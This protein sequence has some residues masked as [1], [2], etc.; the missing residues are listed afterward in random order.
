[1]ADAPI[2]VARVLAAE[3]GDVLEPANYIRG[4]AISGRLRL[5]RLAPGETDP[6]AAIAEAVAPSVTPEALA[7]LRAADG[8]VH[9]GYLWANE[10]SDAT[11]DGRYGRFLAQIADFYLDL[12][13]DGL[14]QPVDADARVEDIF[15]ASSVL[16]R[17]F[18]S[19]A[20]GRYA[21]VLANFLAAAHAQPD[22]GLWWH[23]GA[24]PFYW[25]RGNAFAA[26]G[27]S[28]GLSY[29]PE[30][31]PQRAALEATHRA[32]IETLITHQDSSGAWRQVIDRPDSYLELTATAM[33]GIALSRG[34]ARGWLP[35]SMGYAAAGAWAAVAERIDEAGMV[36]DACMGTGPMPALD[37]YLNRAAVSGH[38]DRAGSMALWFAVE[39][40]SL[41]GDAAP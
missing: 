5:H 4:V 12:R 19:T 40:A 24:S 10:L 25:G 22:S 11:G 21:E 37:D 13:S 34:M 33:I 2:E 1:M 31:H 38:D 3:Y 39:Y 7:A 36:R 6:A 8:S 28:E 18:E 30:A 17:A 35:A 23:C 26:L 14:P 41:I 29:L 15:C 32:H 16:G 9:A 20:D 27:F